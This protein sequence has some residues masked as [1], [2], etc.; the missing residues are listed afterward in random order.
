MKHLNRFLSEEETNT[1]K[2]HLVDAEEGKDDK[3]FLAL[4]GEYKQSR[5]SSSASGQSAASKVFD[6]AIKL[7]TDGDVSQRAK[8]AAAYL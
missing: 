4:M 6:K 2:P 1:T 5:K 3:K 7:A 8:L